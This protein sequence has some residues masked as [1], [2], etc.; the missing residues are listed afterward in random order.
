MSKAWVCMAVDGPWMVLW[1]IY[2]GGGAA[3]W[4][5]G[6]GRWATAVGVLKQ[7]FYVKGEDE[8]ADELKKDFGGKKMVC[9]CQT[10]SE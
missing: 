5:N 4:S 10:V 3:G 2:V 1:P 6:S 7:R 9:A 8:K